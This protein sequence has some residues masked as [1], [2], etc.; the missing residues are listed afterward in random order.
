MSHPALLISTEEL[1][2]PVALA[3][4][5]ALDQELS[6][7]YPEPDA[8]FLELDAEEVAS[9]S[10]AFLVAYLDG[11]PV[12]CGAVRRISPDTAELK[13]M[14]VRPDVRGLGL[15]R[16]LLEE[17][18]RGARALGMRRLVLET[19]ERQP[20]AI[21]LY[22]RAGFTPIERYGAYVASPLSLCMAKTL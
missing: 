4:I 22:R 3:L 15:A 12:A 21:A 18:E 19:G 13:R 1:D 5:S 20:A 14:Y 16:A 10:G 7:L 6:A 2:S 8:N 17:L 11:R 9:D